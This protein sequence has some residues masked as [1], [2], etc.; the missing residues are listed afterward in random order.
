MTSRTTLP[1]WFADAVTALQAGDVDG[2]MAIYAADAIH[3][4]PFAPPGAPK[5]LEGRDAIAN[6]MR[7][8]F[9]AIRFGPLTDVHVLECGEETVIEATG[10]PKRLSDGTTGTLGFIWVISRRE[11]LVTLY[12]DYMNPLQLGEL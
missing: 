3:E 11:G 4:F 1:S 2:W 12:R 6:Y 9:S 8:I 5:R 10:H 7:E